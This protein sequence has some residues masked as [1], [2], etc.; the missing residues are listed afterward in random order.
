[1]RNFKRVISVALCIIMIVS[2]MSTGVEAL[3]GLFSMNTSS[4][5]SEI[6]KENE[7]GSFRI[8]QFSDIQDNSYLSAKAF[9][10]I[11]LAVRKYN[12]NLIVLTGDN[13]LNCKGED[14]FHTT[15]DSLVDEFIDA[16]GNKIPFAVTFGNHDYEVNYLDENK[17]KK[18]SLREQY[19]YYLSKGAVNLSQNGL[20][21]SAVTTAE[22]N[23]ATLWGT[24]YVDV[25]TNDGLKVAKRVILLNTGSYDNDMTNRNRFARVGYNV[26][27]GEEE[28]YSNIVSAVNMWT[29]AQNSAGEKIEC[30]IYQHIALQEIYL[31]DTPATSVLTKPTVPGSITHACY[32]HINNDTIYINPEG[33]GRRQYVVSTNNPTLTGVF[34]EAPKCS[35]NST[36]DL[37]K[38]VAK[39]NVIG[40]FYGHD[41]GNTVSAE[42]KITYDNVQYT[43]TQG[44]GGGIDVYDGNYNGV[45]PQGSCYVIDKDGDLIKEAFSYTGLL[46]EN[47]KYPSGN[48]SIKYIKEVALFNGASFESA[49]DEAREAGFIP[50]TSAFSEGYNYADL[51]SNDRGTRYFTGNGNQYECIGYKQTTNPDEAITDLRI[52]VTTDATYSRNNQTKTYKLSGNESTY[53]IV[54]GCDGN[55]NY[56]VTS[57]T[58]CAFLYYTT[59]KNAGAPLT[60]LIVEVQESSFVDAYRLIDHRTLQIGNFV[61]TFGTNDVS[62]FS[63]V[64]IANFN[65]GAT[66]DSV[67]G[68]SV[69]LFLK[70]YD[71]GSGYNT[72]ISYDT[73][74]GAPETIYVNASS[75]FQCYANDTVDSFGIL[76]KDNTSDAT[77][78]K[79]YFYC[80]DAT[81]VNVTAMSGD[82]SNATALVSCSTNNNTAMTKQA[83]GVFFKEITSG[84]VSDTSGVIKWVFS[85]SVAGSSA[86][87]TQI[88]YS[89]IASSQSTAVSGADKS[90]LRSFLG[91]FKQSTVVSDAMTTCNGDNGFADALANASYVLGNPAATQDDIDKAKNR[92]VSYADNTSALYNPETPD[93]NVKEFIDDCG[94]YIYGI[95][96]PEDEYSDTLMDTGFKWV[97]FDIPCP[98]DKNGYNNGNVKYVRNEYK[99]FKERCAYYKAQGFKILAVTPYPKDLISDMSIENPTG[100]FDA[101]MD[102]AEFVAEYIYNDVKDDGSGKPCVDALQITNEMGIT[103]FTAPLSL[104]Q[105]ATYIG[106]QL[107]AIDG[108]REA[109]DKIQIGYNSADLT[110]TSKYLHELLSPYYQYCDYIAIDLYMGNQGEATAKDYVKK[111][112]DLYSITNKPVVI[113]EFGFW[114]EGGLKTAEQKAAILYD[115]YGYNSEAE[116]IADGQNFIDKLPAQFRKTLLQDYP[117]NADI[118]DPVHRPVPG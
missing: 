110:L 102:I 22:D 21:T 71:G 117:D 64:R 93:N 94:G 46:T 98:F 53:R 72:R 101:F 48:E 55:V 3:G 84:K 54:S 51:N 10:T 95:C 115:N 103:T 78:G 113:T 107:E 38:A 47:V 61:E 17:S 90:A 6:L 69:Y 106:L 112:K 49:C 86:V 4:S 59:N 83:D 65:L 60:E 31:G 99:K 45:D 111:V 5:N 116:A 100:D 105:A 85:Y 11:R 26:E 39:D 80:P 76:T 2:T 42:T 30:I 44:F 35:Y 92:F 33:E 7:D 27:T 8:L 25:Y 56:G 43:L 19:E 12:P 57:N 20:D 74:A 91:N 108:I 67:I 29:N 32:N 88:A 40:V 81:S 114:S 118:S 9:A 14:V 104:E 97:R 82:G 36:E 73:V 41:H 34:D 96:Q 28:S 70:R 66:R 58:S 18:I 87:K 37:F 1:M 16:N 109:D 52:F 62:S 50:V 24:G 89:A 68:D 77:S 63:N 13:V 79:L 23:S 75:D 15:I